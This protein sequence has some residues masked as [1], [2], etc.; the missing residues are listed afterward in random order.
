MSLSENPFSP[1]ATY[2]TQ[3]TISSISSLD[4]KL[5]R[6]HYYDG[7]LLR[8]SD[9][10]R[11]QFYLD[12]RLREVGRALG[13]GIVRGF[14]VTLKANRHLEISGGLAV[15]PSGRV[16]ELESKKLELNLTDAALIHGMNPGFRS[17]E[18]GLYVV[19]VRYAEKGTGSAEIYPRDLEAERGFHFN[20][21]AEGV[22]FAL[23]KLPINLPLEKIQRVSAQEV[24]VY[25]RALLVRQ[26]LLGTV[27]QP[28]VIGE[29]AVALGVLGVE[30]GI[31]QWFDKGLLRRPFR[32]VQA[33]NYVQQDL[34]A[35]YEELFADILS[36]RNSTANQDKFLASRYFF[37]LPPVGSLPKLAIDPINAY[38]HY[39]PEQ[40]EV[41]ISPVR[42]DD[43]PSLIQQS[44]ELE[45]IDLQTDK[46][47][48]ILIAV[49]LDDLNF[50]LIARRLEHRGDK[51]LPH[52]DETLLSPYKQQ[53]PQDEVNIWQKVWD[54]AQKIIYLRRPVRAAET[55]VS[56]VVLAS[57]DYESLPV[58]STTANFDINI[59]TRRLRDSELKNRK[60]ENEF[61][62]KIKE[63]LAQIDDLKKGNNGHIEEEKE[64]VQKASETVEA[65]VDAFEK[66]NEELNKKSKNLQEDIIQLTTEL[67]LL[68]GDELK[69]TK[70]ELV[71]AIAE[72]NKLLDLQKVL[73]TEVDELKKRVKELES[74]G[75]VP[76]TDAEKLKQQLNSL[77]N[78]LV[79][80]QEFISG[81][82]NSQE[83]RL[84]KLSVLSKLRG[85][86]DD[87]ALNSQQMVIKEVEQTPEWQPQLIQLLSL[88]HP[89]F[90]DL[91]WLS[92]DFIFNN[93]MQDK[94]IEILIKNRDSG[95]LESMLVLVK[96]LEFPDELREAWQKMAEKSRILRF[97]PAAINQIKVLKI[98]Q[99][100]PASLDIADEHR[101]AIKNAVSADSGLLKPLSQLKAVVGEHYQALLWATLPGIIE[102]EKLPEFLEFVLKLVEKNLPLGLGVASTNNRFKIS[103]ALR[104]EW[105]EI[106]LQL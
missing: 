23:V 1:M 7:R 57:G 75:T 87:K 92:L 54:S 39:F 17:L 15:T 88:M 10:T 65:T 4:P 9:L 37:V 59:F 101:A 89:Q 27:G 90:D 79:S 106:D 28:Q 55:Q 13:Q 96:E 100:L 60:K 32:S 48:D 6:T 30:Y 67:N 14:D 68:K 70:E 81:L 77:Q 105:A 31:A 44:L 73:Q 86:S 74:G 82:W 53:K 104:N 99:L 2:D 11:D 98:T 40:F 18:P 19:V 85:V 80:L 56:A 38:Q 34:Y 62:E 22:Q 26:L 94:A 8:A 103:V 102:S 5:S 78:Q 97:S 45:P 49:V 25:I 83:L 42:A 47:V 21:Y 16:L 63:L 91:N 69:K 64:L 95:Y 93:K 58:L 72:N 3:K 84:E 66:L 41:S 24:S 71:I 35:H 76:D 61:N 52:L 46:D 20:A 43:L 36:L 50:S 12:E 51:L 29:D 33:L